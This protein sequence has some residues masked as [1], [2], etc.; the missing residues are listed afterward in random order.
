MG[1]FEP[2]AGLDEMIA[3]RVARPALARILT[4][5]RDDARKRAPD[6]RVWV[7]VRDERVRRTHFETDSQVIPGNLRFKLP[8]ARGEGHDLARHPRD[9]DLP[10]EQRANCRCDD[11]TIPELLRESIHATDV[12]VIGTRA[13]GSVETRFPRAAE[14]ENGTSEDKAAHYMLGALREISARLRAGQAL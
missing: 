1:R 3:Q 4:A 13:S 11:P 9:P 10:I 2:R 6:T 12:T 7:T 14:S 5:L 8:K